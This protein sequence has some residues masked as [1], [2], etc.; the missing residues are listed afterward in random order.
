MNDQKQT[1][2]IPRKFRG[3]LMKPA[4]STDG[5]EAG[6]SRWLINQAQTYNLSYLLAYAD[7]GV[8]WG[9]IEN[10]D[11]T[12]SHDVD[13][14]VSPPL[15]VQT[16]RQ[17]RLFSE[18]EGELFVWRTVDGWQARFVQDKSAD[19]PWALDEDYVL[20]GDHY[21]RSQGRFT[22]VVEGAQGL[23]HAVPRS[24]EKSDFR[25]EYHPLRI[26]VRHYLREDKDTGRLFIA[27]S[28]LVKVFKD[29][30]ED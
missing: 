1:G 11:L 20:W 28:R 4:P 27:Y 21:E 29:F 24:L 12:T 6:V 9:R 17:C 10:G 23:R 26:Q 30:K 8:I 5:L 22:L 2:R 14:D 18:D 15:H 19:K 7:D 3:V 13:S 16:L 25:N